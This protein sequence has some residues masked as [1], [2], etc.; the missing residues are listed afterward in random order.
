M[1]LSDAGTLR[2]RFRSC[3]TIIPQQL[4]A[5]HAAGVVLAAAGG[6]A[7]TCHVGGQGHA[8]R[9]PSRRHDLSLSPHQLWLCRQ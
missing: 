6:V 4:D 1:V 8:A 3:Q 5:F 9:H 7:F 2:N